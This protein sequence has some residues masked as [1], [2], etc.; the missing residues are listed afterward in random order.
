MDQ[1]EGVFGIFSISAIPNPVR[2]SCNSSSKDPSFGTFEIRNGTEHIVF[3]R[4]SSWVVGGLCRT[5][6]IFLNE[7]L[8][9]RFRTQSRGREKFTYHRL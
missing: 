3:E 9:P 7:M 6:R 5:T 2:A 1:V 8:P 4:T